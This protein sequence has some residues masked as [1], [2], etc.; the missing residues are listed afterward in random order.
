MKRIAI[1]SA[2]AAWVLLTT[3]AYAGPGKVDFALTLEQ[4]GL[5]AEPSSP[6]TVKFSVLKFKLTTK[7]LLA[8]FADHYGES[9]PAG[10]MLTWGVIYEGTPEQAGCI[11]IVNPLVTPIVVLRKVEPTVF[12]LNPDGLLPE[13]EGLWMLKTGTQSL[14][15]SNENKSLFSFAGYKLKTDDFDLQMVGILREK[16]SVKDAKGDRILSATAAFSLLGEGFAKL[17]VDGPKYT[18]VSGQIKQ[19]KEVNNLGPAE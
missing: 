7:D 19:G 17:T 6:T 18:L 10:A 8:I 14:I 4:Q 11:Q 12:K 2:L 1:L 9:Y 5:V 13:G 15:S 3:D 16:V